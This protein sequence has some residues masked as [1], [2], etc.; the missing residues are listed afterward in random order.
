MAAVT[1]HIAIQCKEYP[2]RKGVPARRILENFDLHLQPGETCAIIGPSGIGKS[3][4][5]QIAAGL[6]LD[7]DGTVSE[8]PA[9]V[10]YLFQT[11]RLLPWLTALQNLE[12]VLPHAPE[13]APHW[14]SRVGL[15]E[16]AH[17]YPAHLS[18]GMARR[19]A[20]ARALC[21]E[22]RLLLLDEPFTALDRETA[23]SMQSLVREDA[24]R[25]GATLLIATH[26]WSDVAA[27][28][29]RTITLGGSPAG[30][31]SD[32]PILRRRAAE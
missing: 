14:L 29:G 6:D 13:K 11:S 4:L 31:V 19:I 1:M 16:A 23:R 8:R 20:L 17:V 26:S 2:R 12:I 28:V 3:S 15:E 5:L 22:P 30:I 27:L 18:V 7:F 32:S 24:A 9:P 21:V 25:L 10:G